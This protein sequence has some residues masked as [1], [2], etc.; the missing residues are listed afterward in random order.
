MRRNSILLSL[1]LLLFHIGLPL[2]NYVSPREVP[3]AAYPGLPTRS[4]SG[5][6]VRYHPDD[7]LFVGDLVSLEVY[8]PTGQNM[9][10]KSIQ[11]QVNDSV[12]TKLGPAEFKLSPIPDR[13]KAT[14]TWAWN[15]QGL[16][17]GSYKL[18]FTI[19]PGNASWTQSVDL[20]PASNLPASIQ[21]AQ[22]ETATI[23]CCILHYISGTPAAR[24]IEYLKQVATNETARV[25]EQFHAQLDIPVLI[26][27]IPRVLGQG[28][29]TSNEI[30]VSYLDQDYAGGTIDQILHHE[31]VHF[32][33]GKLGGDLRPTFL[34]EGLAVYF[35]GGHFKPES[36]PLEVSA[37]MDL[38]WYLPL[39][40]L[41]DNFYPSQ[42]EI[43][44]MEAGAFIQYL[45]EKF[46][47]EAYSSFYRD[48]HPQKDNRQ[49][50]S[51]D[52]ALKAHFG[53]SLAQAEDAFIGW[54]RSYPNL[55]D[56]QEDA[57]LTINYYDT[58]R[59]YE[60]LL[61]PSAYFLDVWLPDPE[62]MM[63]KG[64]VADYLRHPD[65]PINRTLEMQMVTAEHDLRTGEYKTSEQIL[66]KVNRTMNTEIPTT[67]N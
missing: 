67:L 53:I 61:D 65:E 8:A 31:I 2:G 37:L 59:R 55:P 10:K 19:F 12:A 44:Y 60:L 15:T 26:T 27:F 51:I 54:V 36:L 7:G 40:L 38:D 48:I 50:S 46:G 11:I 9:S 43:G 62:E 42:H 3:L 23:A 6:E 14:L 4:S 49:S 47:W 34:V 66:S 33:D 5:F 28:G 64:I 30:I 13:W 21:S 25:L 58:I 52:I 17:A 35:S 16:A 57:A 39:P 18:T 22:W 24:D 41:I 45:V 32:V 56:M 1:C 29:F 63:K 20:L